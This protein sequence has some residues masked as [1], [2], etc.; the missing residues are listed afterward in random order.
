MNKDLFATVKTELSGRINEILEDL[1]PGGRI[2]GGEYVCGSLEGG[3]GQS[4]KTNLQSGVGA[5]FATGHKWGNIIALAAQ[6]W[7]KTQSEAARELAE[8]Y[9]VAIDKDRINRPK[10]T[11]QSIRSAESL[12]PIIPIPEDAPGIQQDT[13][14]TGG[15]WCYRDTHGRALFYVVRHD[16]PD[17]NKTIKPMSYCRNREGMCFWIAK[18]PVGPRPLYGLDRLAKSPPNTPILLVEGEK[19]ADAAQEMFPE[20]VAM[21]WSGGANAVDKSDFS[22]LEGCSV[23]I[24]PDNDEPGIRAALELIGILSKNNVKDVK[25]VYP[26]DCLPKKWDVAD[27]APEGFDPRRSLESAM[28]RDNFLQAVHSRKGE[29]GLGAATVELLVSIEDDFDI[30][31]W[32]E[33]SRDALPGFVG[34]F[35]DLA[36]RDSEADPAAVLATLLARFGAEVY[37]FQKNMGPFI[38]IGESIHPPRLFAVVCGNSSKARKGTSCQPVT[39]LFKRDLCDPDELAGL[40][41]PPTARESGGPLSSGEGLAFPL[42]DKTDDGAS[43]PNPDD[44]RLFVLDQELASGLSCTRREGNTLSMAIRIFWDGGDYA[45][46]TKTKPMQVSG[47]QIC[48]VTHIT[49]AELN[50]LLSNVNMANG[51]GNRFLW[52][53]ARRSKFVALPRPMP[54]PEVTML[55]RRLWRLVAE[56]QKTHEVCLTQEA[57]RTWAA[58]YPEL[59]SETSGLYGAIVN[60][61]E[62]QTMRL[63]LI[64]ALLDGEKSIDTRHI[65]SGFALWKYV[66]ASAACLFGDRAID[67]A[68]QKIEAILKSG[69]Y[70]ATDLNRALSGHMTSEK[71]RCILGQM[72]A[73]NRIIIRQ[74]RT[75]G[76]PR[77]VI[78]LRDKSAFSGNSGNS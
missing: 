4:C 17:G 13:L 30:P 8:R 33:L 34:E 20:Y 43:D 19:T 29:T 5:D 78:A 51:F 48:I 63:S 14:P 3:G 9:G 28:D 18:M 74:E 52:V 65:N 75:D 25:L 31:T 15:M 59:S 7:G 41:L 26:P 38:S 12:I 22:Q 58:I 49:K 66:C 62:A 64:Y 53:C 23:L 68:E 56:A 1:L 55:Q 54:L 44:K 42:R 11:S 77:K 69:P 67:P 71:L 45:P 39:R 40:N 50:F 24:W 57:M 36:T 61:A 10:P 60:R 73:A 2:I 35:I 27:P 6:V 70:T 46:L 76:R 16:K 37:G 72:E 21:T 47:A 32:P